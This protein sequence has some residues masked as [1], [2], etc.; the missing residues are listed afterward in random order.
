MRE[1][2]TRSPKVDEPAVNH[3][4]NYITSSALTTSPR[5]HSA[6]AST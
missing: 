1:G 2:F 6:I 3:G 4:K 5:S